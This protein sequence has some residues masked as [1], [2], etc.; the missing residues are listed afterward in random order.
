MTEIQIDQELDI[1]GEVCPFT[2]VKSKLA[3]ESMDSA[4]VL[5]IITDYEPATDNVPRSMQAEGHEVISIADNN[6]GEWTIVVRKK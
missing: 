1:R 3:L 4:K 5:R 6:D 2:F